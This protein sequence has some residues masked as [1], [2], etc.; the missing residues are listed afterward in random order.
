MRLIKKINCG[1]PAWLALMVCL[2]ALTFL[3]GAAAKPQR[4]INSDPAR[5]LQGFDQQQEMKK[6]GPFKDLQWQFL[7]PTNVSGRCTDVAVLAPKGK[8][9]TMFV[10]TASGGLWKTD[11]EGTT[12]Q[13][14]FENGPST[15]IGDVAVAP[16]DSNI[17]WIGT[18][19]ANIFRSSQA[20]CGVY[21]SIDAGQTWQHMGLSDTYTIPRII[22]HPKNPDIVYV[23]AAGHEWTSNSERGVFKTID[24][25]KN[26]QKILF[27]SD[28]AGAID[29]AMDPVD[30]ETLYTAVWQRTRQ[31]WN[32]PRNA[33]GFN[34]SG[35]YRSRDSGKTWQSINN[36]LPE[37]KFRGRIGIDIACSN[38]NVLYALVDNYE[39]SRQPTPEELRNPYGVPSCGFIKG[40]TVY[41]SQDKG[42]SWQQVSGLTPE[43][44]KFME[45]HSNT[46]GWVFG[47][48]RVDPGDANT[49]YIMG[50]PL[51]VSNDGG[52]T[53]RHLRGMHVDHHGLWID[54]ANPNYLVNANDG[55]VCVSYDGGKNWR[56]FTDNLPVCQFFNVNYDMASPFHVFGSMQDHGSFRGTV[57]LSRGRDRIPAVAFEYTPGGEGSNH[58]IDPTDPNLVYSASF[59][60]MLNRS[61]ISR[62]DAASEKT[63]VPVSYENEPRLR[64]QWLAP[65]IIS[66][67]NPNIIYHGMQFLF[68]SQDRG[69]TWEKISPDLT[70]NNRSEMGDIPYHT[71]FAIAESPLKYGLIYVGTDDGLVHVS[72]DGGKSWTEINKGLPSQK[73]ISRLVASQYEMGTVYMTQNGKRDDD[74][75]PYVW[76]SNDY[77]KTWQDIAKG[78]PVGPVNVIREDPKN[79]AGLY[80][81]TD[82]GV[83]V[84]QDNGKSWQVL[85]GNLP[86][87]YVHDLIIHPRDNIIVIA[88]H[89]RGMWALDANPLNKQ[90]EK[91]EEEY[92]LK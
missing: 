45:R 90:E 91:E 10:A 60:G 78:I 65:F 23:A 9:Y 21:K 66:S 25:G 57:N 88:T 33:P 71:I 50:V 43:M 1:K 89:G 34:Q 83:F 29:L 68:R 39:I 48:I 58:A 44:K 62:T 37:A 7:G 54:P 32:D 59:Y 4:I 26:W 63:I 40:A 42:D 49:V 5:R 77:G 73:W 85:G 35:I 15:A 72:R 6:N 92:S 2:L 41:R 30:H 47:Q 13:P 24:G 27:I 51:S 12:W 86:A 14:V 31:K 16:A 75:T 11:N 87:V 67:H 81:G 64:G 20:G 46:Y 79:S 53:F 38:S 56:R 28:Q 74:F 19:E 52:K 18:G 69:D 55:G 17:I 22:I 36:G 3:A 8:N 70:T 76:K 84:S 61:D 82:S 80:L